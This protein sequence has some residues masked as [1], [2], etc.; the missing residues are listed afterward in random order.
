MLIAC[1]LERGEL[2]IFPIQVARIVV[3]NRNPSTKVNNDRIDLMKLNALHKMFCKMKRLPRNGTNKKQPNLPPRHFQPPSP[4]KVKM[5]SPKL[6][7][8]VAAVLGGKRRGEG[9]GT[10]PP[11]CRLQTIT[12]LFRSNFTYRVLGTVALL[13]QLV[14]SPGLSMQLN[15]LGLKNISC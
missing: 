7:P 4:S 13:V 10:K 9:V 1:N 6:L 12:T 5:T 3:L 11:I 2:S 8:I 15:S 14:S